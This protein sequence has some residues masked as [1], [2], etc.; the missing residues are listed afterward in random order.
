MFCSG[1]SDCRPLPAFLTHI[2]S[3]LWR[4]AAMHVWS[5]A[6]TDTQKFYSPG[7]DILT[8]RQTFSWAMNYISAPWKYRSY[9]T[10]PLTW[11]FAHNQTHLQKQ[12]ENR[13]APPQHLITPSEGSL[14]MWKTGSLSAFLPFPLILPTMYLKGTRKGAGCP[15]NKW[16]KIQWKKHTLQYHLWLNP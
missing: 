13:R 10:S 1:S 9:A 8:E 14:E 16:G 6:K 3:L 12:A 4:Q 2:L 7:R 5:Q 11:I 15:G